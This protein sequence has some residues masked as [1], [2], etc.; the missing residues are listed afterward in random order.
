MPDGPDDSRGP[1]SDAVATGTRRRARNDAF[2]AAMYVRHVVEKIATLTAGRLL[3]SSAACRLR[4]RLSAPPQPRSD[5]RT[6]VVAHVFYPDLLPEI[7][8][9]RRFLPATSPLHVTVPGEKSQEARQR[10][11]G[12]P[13]VVVH[14]VENRGRD[15]APL[16]Q[17]LNAGVLAPFD[18]VL[19]IHT[20]R[21]P[22]LRDGDIRRRLLYLSLAGRPHVVA[23]I[24]D[25]FAQSQAGV[26]GWRPSYRRGPTY[27]HAN[28]ARARELVTR[29][30]G[31]GAALEAGFFEGSMFWF[32][33]AALEPIRRLGLSASDFEPERGQLDG[34]LHHVVERIL[35]EAARIE[36]YTVHDTAGRRL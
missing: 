17:L 20:K 26:V 7:V 23:R 27:W 31:D 35:A 10:V 15:I 5:V 18:A 13:N 25:M 3:V 32:R 9:C 34:A 22:H 28:E 8:A 33:P 24:L 1:S 21:S 6:A 16:L 4:E 19:K 36:G 29:L 2:F 11:R 30:G 14:E 12:L